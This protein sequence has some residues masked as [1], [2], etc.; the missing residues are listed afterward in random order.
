MI[1]YPHAMAKLEAQN[2]EDG[3]YTVT[4]ILNGVERT[5]Q[6]IVIGGTG[7]LLALSELGLLPGD[8]RILAV[9]LDMSWTICPTCGHRSPTSVEWLKHNSA[10]H[11]DGH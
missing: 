8:P 7:T 11:P 9:R 5:E 2:L 1:R 6:D 10:V 3:A 4:Y